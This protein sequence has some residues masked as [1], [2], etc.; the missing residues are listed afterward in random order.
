MGPSCV[1]PHNPDLSLLMRGLLKLNYRSAIRQK[2]PRA[3]ST[4][5]LRASL[6]R[7]LARSFSDFQRPQRL[8]KEKKNMNNNSISDNC[9]VYELNSSFSM[10]RIGIPALRTN[11]AFNAQ[12]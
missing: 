2:T 11:C 9:G 3:A 10:K 1:E 12:K 6:A 8:K 5:F 4:R 7:S